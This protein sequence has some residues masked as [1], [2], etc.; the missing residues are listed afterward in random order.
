M[1]ANE[2]HDTC[3]IRMAKSV[4]RLVEIPHDMH[5]HAQPEQALK[6]GQLLH[7]KILTLIDHQKWITQG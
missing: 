5:F 2:T 7:R 1:I 6:D 3:R 4:N